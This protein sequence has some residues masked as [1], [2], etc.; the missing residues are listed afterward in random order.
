MRIHTVTGPTVASRG[1]SPRHSSPSSVFVDHHKAV[2]VIAPS[3]ET[4]FV[5]ESKAS[6]A[7]T[8]NDVNAEKVEEKKISFRD[9][10]KLFEAK[11]PKSK[12][13]ALPP[14]TFNSDKSSFVKNRLKLMEQQQTT[15][16]DVKEAVKPAWQ[17]H[18]RARKLAV[19]ATSTPNSD[20]T[21]KATE[22][23]KILI[24]KELRELPESNN[25][26]EKTFQ[27]EKKEEILDINNEPERKPAERSSFS[28]TSSF[29]HYSNVETMSAK[30][31]KPPPRTHPD[32]TSQS[33]NIDGT[34]DEEDEK[35]VPTVK[36]HM[37]AI[38]KALKMSDTSTP[39]SNSTVSPVPE[40]ALAPPQA[41]SLVA[42]SALSERM[43]KGATET[44]ATEQT[45]TETTL[46]EKT[47]TEPILTD[48]T[49]TQPTVTG[50]TTTE[51]IATEKALDEKIMTE[52]T[53]TEQI[54]TEKMDATVT[55]KK[56]TKL[57]MKE[58]NTTKTAAATT[59]KLS[60][61]AVKKANLSQM[62]VKPKR[63]ETGLLSML[64]D[65]KAKGKA[66]RVDSN[67]FSQYTSII[68]AHKKEAEEL[69]HAAMNHLHTESDDE[70]RDE[71]VA[72]ILGA[73]QSRPAPI[74]TSSELVLSNKQRRALPSPKE[75]VN[76]GPTKN[77]L[78]PS[79]GNA[80]SV[81][82]RRIPSSSLM[83]QT[84]SQ[85][86]SEGGPPTN[87]CTVLAT[88]D[89]TAEAI[90]CQQE[91]VQCLPHAN[92]SHD[93]VMSESQASSFILN[94]NHCRNNKS[95]L[96]LDADD[97]EDL[98]DFKEI[99]LS[100]DSGAR[101]AFDGG[102]DASGLCEMV[103]TLTQQA[104]A[105]TGMNTRLLERQDSS[106]DGDGWKMMLPLGTSGQVIVCEPTCQDGCI[107]T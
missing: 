38:Q 67:G 5:P 10:L 87:I 97:S 61:A 83:E 56:G 64:D 46:T 9:K 41:P 1:A 12:E 21:T 32:P 50:K 65:L 103:T 52:A 78:I 29:T 66:N 7:C 81:S 17:Q 25:H 11:T 6:N 58:K 71:H 34:M 14:T 89:L 104:A 53:V 22:A 15:S 30:T 2:A 80:L 86:H 54:A 44:T 105:A 73:L 102:N 75:G 70:A 90:L 28:K 33:Q 18:C 62:V 72:A 77:Q 31:K 20:S 59:E 37:V 63:T 36:D 101:G 96:L 93:D 95:G 91:V 100:I 42:S 16:Q 35:N 68:T 74:V 8:T 13:P 51:S 26:S 76:R 106:D 82:H 92:S 3:K 94:A 69:Q 107:V 23:G 55:E 45:A 47:T 60:P 43:E 48:K 57:S 27:E 79:K 85:A 19:T 40:Q 84:L 98:E 39:L 4:K 24:D 99:V 88:V 49:A